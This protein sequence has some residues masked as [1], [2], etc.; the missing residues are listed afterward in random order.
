MPDYESTDKVDW[1]MRKMTSGW[2]S[3]KDILTLAVT[4]F[5]NTSRKKLEGTIGQYWSDSQNPKW[6]LYKA[7]QARGLKVITEPDGRRSIAKDGD[8]P[9]LPSSS[10]TALSENFSRRPA[11]NSTQWA[12]QFLA[13]SEL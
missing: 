4:E 1:F 8:V 3:R 5:P 9:V 10:I 7:I 2:F 11:R 6:P 13:A 12:A